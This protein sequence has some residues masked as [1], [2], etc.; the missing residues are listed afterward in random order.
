MA[1]AVIAEPALG[2]DGRREVEAGNRLYDEG[3]FQ[4]AHARYLEA[5]EKVPG[6]PVARF[7]EGSALYRS[8]EFQRAME[9]F[10]EAA[11]ARIRRGRRTPCTT[12]GTR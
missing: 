2:Q 9:A 7:N 12:S 1:A 4:E 10:L 6:L 11:E 8:Q 3:R 5:L